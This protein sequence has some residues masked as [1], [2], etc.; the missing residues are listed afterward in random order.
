[1]FPADAT[2]AAPTPVGEIDGLCEH[3]SVELMGL[4]ASAGERGAQYVGHGRTT[5]QSRVSAGREK[6]RH[7]TR[8]PW[9]LVS[10]VQPSVSASGNGDYI[11]MLETGC[12]TRGSICRD[13]CRSRCNRSQH[14]CCHLP[15]FLDCPDRH[16]KRGTSVGSRRGTG[17]CSGRQPSNCHSCYAGKGG[18]RVDRCKLIKSQEGQEKTQFV[19]CRSLPR[20]ALKANS[21]ALYGD[22]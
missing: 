22:G 21:R 4:I 15:P 5:W 11:C 1:M 10:R 12:S 16:H 19:Q 3:V 20:E 18:S 8:V 7:V 6:E 9:R 17:S 14:A 2:N 13:S